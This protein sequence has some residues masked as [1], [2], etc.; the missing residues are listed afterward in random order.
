MFT[1]IS[2]L[3]R[4]NQG[5][6]VCTREFFE[7]NPVRIRSGGRIT[8]IRAQRTRFMT[9]HWGGFSIQLMYT[10]DNPLVEQLDSLHVGD[11]V[12]IDGLLTR[13]LRGELSILPTALHVCSRTQHNLELR[14]DQPEN[15]EMPREINVLRNETLAQNLRTRSRLLRD[16]R[17]YMYAN[18]FDEMQTPMLHENASGA[19][20][21]TFETECYANNRPY[22][23]RIAPEIYL[24]RAMASGL[25][26]V[27]ELGQNFRN[28]GI[29]NRHQPEFT[30]MECYQAFADNRWAMDYLESML[31]HIGRE[32]QCTVLQQR[33]EQLDYREALRRYHPDLGSSNEAYER[34]NSREWLYSQLGSTN[35]ETSLGMLQFMVFETI[36]HRIVT[37]TFIT[38]QPREISP[39]AHINEQGETE[40]FELFING[41][42]LANGFSQLI[43]VEEQRRRFE[44]QSGLGE[45]QSMRTD[46]VYL[47]SMAYGFSRIGGFGIGIDRLLMLIAGA[48]H[49]RDV[50]WYPM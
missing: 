24:V 5:T 41:R 17:Q 31:N 49:I 34:M 38:N 48:Q 21:R 42:E 14:R 9:L 28:E 7:A 12:E 29:S 37:P 26:R 44:M 8:A 39:L 47:Q 33:F 40:R 15:H 23:L 32:Y 16:I 25:D 27:F 46:Q 30:M 22:H 13:S 1:S 43:N 10:Q 19:S 4:Y 2:S 6:S 3:Q 50:V 18:E 45:D 36:D 20:A 35:P 11:V